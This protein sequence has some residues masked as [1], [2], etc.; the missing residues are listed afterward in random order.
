MRG[1]LQLP[2]F[3]EDVSLC[4]AVTIKAYLQKVS[5]MPSF[6]L[7]LLQC[8]RISFLRKADK[9]KECDESSFG[10]LY[11]GEIYVMFIL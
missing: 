5:D 8:D 11:T 9:M 3:P 6:M 10:L 1:Y 2:T 7:L 4:P